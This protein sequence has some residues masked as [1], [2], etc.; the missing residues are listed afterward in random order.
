MLTVGYSRILVML[1]SIGIAAPEALAAVSDSQKCHAAKLK[2][3]GKFY[4]CRVKARAKFVT[5]GDSEKLGSA[6]AKCTATLAKKVAKADAKWASACPTSGDFVHLR[7]SL[8]ADTTNLATTLSGG[9]ALPDGCLSVTGSTECSNDA[10]DLI[11]CAGTTQDGELQAGDP[12]SFTD[13][14]DGTITDENTGL[15]WEKKSDDSGIHDVDTSYNWG[16]AFLMHIFSLN[17]SSFAGYND[18]R[19]PNIRELSSISGFGAN[20]IP[21]AFD[22]GCAPGCTV[23]TCSCAASAR[24]WSSTTVPDA[25]SNAYATQFGDSFGNSPKATPRPVRAVR[26]GL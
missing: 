10:G 19:L 16:N 8:S 15:M 21:P 12:F 5:K 9:V 1:V 20:P 22:N 17:F 6:L 18:W 4:Q 11:P 23:V 7:N 26:G 25:T 3:A 2:H 24:N 14:G 13:N